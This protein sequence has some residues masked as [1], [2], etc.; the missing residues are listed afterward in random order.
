[1][2][3]YVFVA[4]V[5]VLLGLLVNNHEVRDEGGITRG[6]ML[7]GLSLLSVFLILFREIRN[8]T[9]LT[10]QTVQSSFH[11]TV[12]VSKLSFLFFHLGF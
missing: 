12:F 4:I 8:L 9:L 3:L 11:L 5:T 7:N 6:Q 1:M 10:F 2:I